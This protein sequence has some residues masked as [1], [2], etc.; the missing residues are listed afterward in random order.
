MSFWEDTACPERHPATGKPCV[1]MLV[2]TVNEHDG[3]INHW[4]GEC[5]DGSWTTPGPVLVAPATPPGS[6][7][8]EAA[9]ELPTTGLD[10]DALEAIESALASY[11]RGELAG[12]ELDLVRRRILSE[13]AAHPEAPPESDPAPST[14]EAIGKLPANSPPSPPAETAPAL[15]TGPTAAWCPVHDKCRCA[16]TSEGLPSLSDPACPLHAATS[17]HAAPAA[18]EVDL[19]ED[20]P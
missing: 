8:R 11:R 12:W 16:L 19:G 15:C 13:R 14:V 10:G 1:L 17:P 20:S 9:R 3:T 7:L 2:H 4:T 6:G 18:P 5:C